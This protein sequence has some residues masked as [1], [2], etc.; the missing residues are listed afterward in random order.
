MMFLARAAAVVAAAL[1]L[2]GCGSLPSLPGLPTSSAP[3]T[4][5]PASSAPAGG[6]EQSVDEACTSLSS[7]MG[8]AT[9]TLQT[10]LADLGND[11]AKAVAALQEF[12]GSLAGAAADVENP[13]V[14]AQVDKAVAALNELV[15]AIQAGIEDPTKL[16]EVMAGVGKV[17]AEL[18]AIGTV[19]SG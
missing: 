3:A 10:A 19:C 6:S 7:T 15:T 5:A 12:A 2:T 8:T 1:A 14:R 9:D 18:T 17:Q 11:P 13:E 4:S 16:T